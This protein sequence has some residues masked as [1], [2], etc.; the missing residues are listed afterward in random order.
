[1]LEVEE[2]S[3]EARQQ[4]GRSVTWSFDED[5]SKVLKARLPAE[6]GMLVLKALEAAMPDLPLPKEDCADAVDVGRCRDTDVSAGTFAPGY[7]AKVS[8]AARRAA[9]EGTSGCG[10]RRFLA[11]LVLGRTAAF[12]EKARAT[13]AARARHTRTLTWPRGRPL[14]QAGDVRIRT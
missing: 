6:A 10:R 4:A 3:R 9:G 2:L 12:K 5:G 7:R 13:C 14:P 11:K 8:K 1:V